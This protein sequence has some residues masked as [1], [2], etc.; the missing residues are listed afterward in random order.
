MQENDHINNAVESLEN[1]DAI[2][3]KKL[4]NDE[5]SVRLY[6][7]ISLLKKEM[8]NQNEDAA[9]EDADVTE[10]QTFAPSA[11]GGA[12]T[13]GGANSGAGQV[14]DP[15]DDD[16]MGEI[17]SAFGLGDEVDEEEVVAKD[18]DLSLD[19][20]FEKEY[21]FKEMNYKGHKITIKQLGLGL[22][23]PVRAYVNGKRW[24]LFPGP[25]VAM[26]TTKTYVDEM[27]S[28][29]AKTSTEQTE[30]DS[31]DTI[32][33]K[34]EIDGRTSMYKKTVGRLESFRKMRAEKLKKLGETANTKN[35]W[36]GLYDDGSGKGAVIPEAAIIETDDLDHA[37]SMSEDGKY[38]IDEEELSPKQKKYRAFFQKT[39]KQFKAKSPA[40]LKGDKKKEFFNYVKKNY[41]G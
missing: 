11:A 20:N 39:L 1:S 30:N 27:I 17:E 21:F 16:V 6:K 4:I 9:T 19:P 37:I 31:D 3:F 22:S 18:E 2:G 36:S 34:V 12:K 32:T 25:D 7:R 14:L 24:E 40:D 28:N 41:K 23:K 13:G 26:K 33:E 10:A 8:Q 38:E 5:L 15:L 29:E 35:K